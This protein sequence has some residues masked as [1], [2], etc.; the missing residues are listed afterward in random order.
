VDPS[1][2]LNTVVR[3]VTMRI[4]VSARYDRVVG[5]TERYLQYLLPALASLGHDVAGLYETE[6]DQPRTR[7]DALVSDPKAFYFKCGYQPRV[8]QEVA[9]WRPDVVFSHGLANAELERKLLD[10]WPGVM[11]AHGYYGTCISGSKRFVRPSLSVCSRTFGLGCL[12][13]YYPRGCGGLDPFVGIRQFR[14][15]RSRRR[16][17][18]S[19]KAILVASGHMKTEFRRHVSH[20]DRVRVVPLFAPGFDA[21]DVPPPLSS[22]G[23]ILFIGRFSEVKG[24]GHLIEAVAR[25]RT[26]LGREVR[27]RMVGDGPLRAQWI[28]L[29]RRLKVEAEFPGWIEPPRL[30]ELMTSAA[31][32]AVPSL[33]PEP[34]A[35]VGIESGSV[36]LPSVGYDVGGISDWL[37]PGISGELAPGDPPTIAGM[38]SALA[39]V[40]GDP[41]YRIQLGHGAWRVA[42]E[43]SRARHVEAVARILREAAPQ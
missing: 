21:L 23:D 31:V 43:H 33:W 10:V 9:H 42:G 20:A 6:L 25:L 35:L 13:A 24:G 5:G 36:G 37:R 7:L 38:A 4:L 18:D 11:F 39:R 12:A 41:A 40:L 29:A 27:L 3:V 2:D 30:R 22:G 19:Y 34:F 17:L 15:Q 32:L 26:L 8:L 28:E 14:L 1:V 16:L